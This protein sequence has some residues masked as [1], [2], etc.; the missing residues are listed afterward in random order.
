MTRVLTTQCKGILFT[1]ISK[2]REMKFIKRKTVFILLL[3]L[4]LCFVFPVYYISVASETKENVGDYSSFHFDTPT[5]SSIMFC[6]HSRE[7]VK[8]VSCESE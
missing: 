4:F 3:L 8:R 6:L 5:P 2:K 7:E 1:R